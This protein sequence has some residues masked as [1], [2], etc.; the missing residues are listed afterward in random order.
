MKKLLAFVL[1]RLIAGLLIVAPIY[2]AILLLFKAAKSIVGLVRPLEK[3]LPAWLRSEEFVALF[4]VL[5]ACF[6]IGIVA[7]TAPGQSLRHKIEHS[8]FHRIPGYSL[9]R[10]FTQ[11]LAGESSEAWKPALAEIEEALVPAFIIEELPDKRLTVFVPSV[12]TPFAGSVY[13]LTP[14]RVHPLDVPFTD[15]I[16]A[17]SRWGAGSKKLVAAMRP[18]QNK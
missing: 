13:V 5:V 15:A 14:E 8:I 12:P 3:L 7:R 18:T 11:Q 16:K 2:L 17:V 1:S 9:I 4:V 10:S 6:L